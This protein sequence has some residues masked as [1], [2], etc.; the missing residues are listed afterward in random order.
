MICNMFEIIFLR[1]ILHQVSSYTHPHRYIIC[2]VLMCIMI[3]SCKKSFRYLSKIYEAVPNSFPICKIVSIHR[4]FVSTGLSLS[5][6]PF[7]II[8]PDSRIVVT[9]S[10]RILTQPSGRVKICRTKLWIKPL[11]KANQSSG[12]SI[13]QYSLFQP[14]KSMFGAQCEERTLDHRA[15][16][17]PF[18]YS[19]HQESHFKRDVNGFQTFNIVGVLIKEKREFEISSGGFNFVFVFGKG[20]QN[21][22]LIFFRGDR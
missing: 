21:P 5:A 13:D 9:L 1:Q 6:S 15:I 3:P 8:A 4:S 7:A 11:L 16:R 2:E 22:P 20:F 12:R 10:I 18:T 14:Q 19:S 17:L